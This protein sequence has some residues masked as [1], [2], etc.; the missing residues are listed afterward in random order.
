MLTF[1]THTSPDESGTFFNKPSTTRHLG[2]DVSS[3]IKPRLN[4][5][6]SMSVAPAYQYCQP[7]WSL[8]EGDG[9]DY[10]EYELLPSILTEPPSGRVCSLAC[11]MSCYIYVA[12]SIPLNNF[13]FGVW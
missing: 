9:N 6:S 5:P 2:A 8:F 12:E 10:D 11:G 1:Y 7:P 3:F 13:G 4:F